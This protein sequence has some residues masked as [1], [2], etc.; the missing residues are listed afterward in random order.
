[1]LVR[2][3]DHDRLRDIPETVESSALTLE[4]INDIERC[5]SLA[6][7]VL[8]VSDGIANDTLEERLQYTTSLF[9]D[10]CETY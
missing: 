6:L 8:S 5:D 7:G 4:G 9:V 10:H 2:R 1:M 3:E